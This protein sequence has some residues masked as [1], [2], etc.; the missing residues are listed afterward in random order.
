MSA[1]VAPDHV[2]E[3]RGRSISLGAFV[4]ACAFDRAGRTAAFALGDG[5]LRLPPVGQDSWPAASAHDGAAL[6]LATDARDGFLSGGDDGRLVRV[7]ADATVTPVAEY[8]MKWVEHVASF[9]DGRSSLLAC[10]VGKQVHV[11][12]GAGTALKSLAHQSTVTGIAF[13]ARGKR[14]AASHYGGASVWFVASK[15]DN[16]RMLEWKGSHTGVT[17]SPDGDAVVTAMQENALHG[18]R[19]SDGQHMRMSGYP[20]KTTSMSF[21]RT[22]KWL[23]TSGA[24]AVVLWPFFGG[25]PMGKAPT[26]LAGGGSAIC[27]AVACHPSHDAVAAGFADGVVALA[28]IATARVLPV[29]GP[30]RGPVSAMAWS[31]DGTFLAFGTETGFAALVDFSERKE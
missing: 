5:T 3:T 12:D 27:T 16:P 24:E 19:L 25:G 22:G 4:V 31:G 18:W 8:G 7:G 21:S 6:S 13:D 29:A 1:R 26:E 15:S 17:V 2:L 28:D 23:A 20:A 11:F 9:T 14:I 30:G 10:A